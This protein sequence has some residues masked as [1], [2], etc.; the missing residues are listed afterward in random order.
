MSYFLSRVSDDRKG[1]HVPFTCEP[2]PDALMQSLLAQA[3]RRSYPIPLP[4]P[5]QQL[6]FSA[7]GGMPTASTQQPVNQPVQQSV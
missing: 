1:I 3:T 2:Q 4:T 7:R 5:R 6:L